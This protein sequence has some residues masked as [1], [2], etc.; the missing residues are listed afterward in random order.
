MTLQDLDHFVFVYNMLHLNPSSECL[1]LSER[2]LGRLFLSTK[3]SNQSSY[4][5]QHAY[6]LKVGGAVQLAYIPLNAEGTSYFYG[7]KSNG[8]A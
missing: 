8:T 1:R 4:L 2:Q 5:L 6:R 7:L 3:I